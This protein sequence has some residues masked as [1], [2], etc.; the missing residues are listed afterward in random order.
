MCYVTLMV[1]VIL[2]KAMP[3]LAIIVLAT[4]LSPPGVFAQDGNCTA[5]DDSSRPDCPGAISFFDRIQSAFKDNDRT[6]IASMVRYPLLTTLN[7]H[8]VY[9]RNR[10]E[11]LSHFDEVF[12]DGVRSAISNATDRDV[13]GNWR[14]FM[15]G[16]GAVWFDAI[17]PRGEKPDPKAADYWTKYPFKIITINNA[18]GTGQHQ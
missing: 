13:W 9:I 3:G 5:K 18:G 12:D 1:K 6:A 2:N 4:L 16:N 11:L 10:N 15:I 8:K 17:I 14:G 7:H